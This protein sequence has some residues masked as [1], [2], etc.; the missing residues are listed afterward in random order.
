MSEWWRR[1]W[2][3]LNRARFERELREEMEAHRAQM[4]EAGAPFGN[5]LR[6]RDE[7]V[8][9]WGWRW[10][11]RLIQDV[12]F[13][14]RLLWRAPAFTLTA[15]A[16][17]ALGVGVNLAAFQVFDRLA[18]SPRPVRDAHT[19]VNLYRRS[20]TSTTTTF[21]YPAFDFYRRH[22][23]RLAGAMALVPA[24]VAIGD[25]ESRHVSAA[26]VTGNYF[27]EMGAV[28]VAG[29]LLEPADERPDAPPVV[30][31]GE[32][33]W[34]AALSADDRVV[35]RV[36]LV[37]G[38]PFTVAGIV[39]RTFVGVGS[40]TTAIWI[41]IARHGATFPG[42]TLL[43][44][45]SG[46]A[47]QFYGRV[48]DGDPAAA[49][50]ELRGLAGAL[51]EQR[52]R[53]VWKDEWLEIREASRLVSLEEAAPAFALIGTLVGLVLVAACMNLGL[54]VLARTLVRDRE[55][56]IRLSVGAT[57][58]RLARQLLTEHLLL[59]LLGAAAGSVVAVQA[60][61]VIFAVTDTPPGIQSAVN[62]RT[63]A[64]ASA[65]AVLSSVVF[66][67]APVWQT[68]RPAAARRYRMR[69][70]LLGA[71][72]MAASALLIVS[73]LLVRGVTRVVRVSLGFDYQQTLVADPDLVSHGASPESAQAYW[74]R[75]DARL[76]QLGA[77]RN[78]AIA[79]L[80]PLGNRVNV[81]SERT[82]FYDVTPDYFDT[83]LIPLR[84]GR[85]FA[86]GE[87]DVVVVSE[88]LAG[89]RWPGE[90]PLGKLYDGQ[91]VVGIVG[92]ARTVRLSEG[93]ASECYRPI[94]AADMPGAVLIA[95]V[96][97]APRLAAS[98]V[99]SI[100]HDEDARVVPQVVA[101]EEALAAKLSGHRQ[102][103]QLV[104]LL[105]AS[106]LL[107]AV[108]GL[109]GMVSFTVSQRRREIGVRL[110]LGARPLHVM[111]TVIGQFRVPVVA[112]AA[113][114]SALAA[115][116]GAVL[117]SE[118]YG[119]SRFDPVAHLGALV[120]FGAVTA[121]AVVPSLRRAAR[122]DPVQTLRHE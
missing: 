43:E 8:D 61:A 88:S 112:G 63:V 22:A 58:W 93:A 34:R 110:A 50:A 23:S 1:L 117:S 99:G 48:P 103:A 92:N 70:V 69:A 122:V 87:Q 113:A 105:G 83:L 7:A 84:R 37:N 6:L 26:F 9:A 77:I 53:D 102:A 35:G 114:G 47:V 66:G 15:V 75:V 5:A 17:L 12:R 29:R 25:D 41:P 57:R 46:G 13:G 49:E 42:S 3:L 10:L 81:N 19:L 40:P 45:W 121:L 59:G 11:D 39:P 82:V 80:P 32:D 89:R 118:L 97:G 71:Q 60:T 14:T 96:D 104:S 51:R 4:T 119:V 30:A 55:F 116:A 90:D 16:V 109:G 101:L 79:T 54:L 115:I 73:G 95:R 106:A 98:T 27:H 24:E 52:P 108:T 67:F 38:R 28:P 56:A 76:R 31:V 2:F 65:L 107:L 36:L 85:I 74:G 64:V 20:P 120:L 91:T 86:T 72:V 62:V 33:L 18:L 68:L 111:R 78:V 94:K 44:D 21:S 100:L